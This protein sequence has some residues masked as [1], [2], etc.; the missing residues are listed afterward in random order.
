M[1]VLVG[2]LCSDGVVI[3]ADSSAT[4]GP[5]AGHPTIEQRVQKV[6]VVQDRIIIAGTGQI[7]ACQRFNAAIDHAWNNKKF[8][9]ISSPTDF[10]KTVCRV[11]IEDFASTEMKQGSFGAL[12][13]FPTKAGL[14][15]CEFAVA[16]FQPELKTESMWFA[17]MGSGQ[18]ITDPFLG[19]MRRVFFPSGQPTVKE[20][21]FIATWALKHAIE[22]N[23]GGINGPPQI[24][25]L[26]QNGKGEPQARILTE[27]ELEEHNNSVE[28]AERH[29]ASYK[30]ILTGSTSGET[31][32]LP[33]L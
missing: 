21:L 11:G 3:G 32:T 27:D 16:D 29:L 24:A 33:T 9:G 28:A 22:L 7:G 8:S 15:L 31:T 1:T 25:T 23:P 19:L 4:F 17:S 6:F 18:P 2:I 14:S 30:N 10:G 13:A 12:V 5:H 20:G 26:Q